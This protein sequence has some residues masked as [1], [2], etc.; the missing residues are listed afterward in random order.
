MPIRAGSGGLKYAPPDQGE[1]MARKAAASA[2][3]G[4][5]ASSSAFAANRQLVAQ[6]RRLKY[7]A[8]QSQMD[9]DFKAQQ[10]Y[11]QRE[12]E[13]GGQLE[14]EDFRAGQQQNQIDARRREDQRQRE[15]QAGQAKLGRDFQLTRDENQ[16]RIH[17]QHDQLL[18]RQHQDQFEAQK[19]AHIEDQLRT[20]KAVLPPESQKKLDKIEGG[21]ATL[22]ELDLG[23]DAEAQFEKQAADRRRKLLRTATAPIAPTPSA[24]ANKTLVHYDPQQKKYVDPDANGAFPPGT[25]VGHVQKDGTFVA[26]DHGQ[27]QQQQKTQENRSKLVTKQFQQNLKAT[28]DKGKPLYADEN[29]AAAAAVEQIDALEKAQQPPPGIG[30]VHVAEQGALPAGVPPQANVPQDNLPPWT[31]TPNTIPNAPPGSYAG[32]Q[33]APPPGNVPVAPPQQQ[34]PAGMPPGSQWADGNT[35]RLPNGTLIRRKGQ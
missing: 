7:D 24:Q 27:Q 12:H 18:L 3:A 11:Y 33:F 14:A 28:D 1:L 13:M 32:S 19:D 16:L 5:S 21:R 35:I 2:S 4:G 31:P 17:A 25:V 23:P 30:D 9:Q 8:L 20:G 22:G 34:L 10:A 15:F 6:D 29:K 26:N